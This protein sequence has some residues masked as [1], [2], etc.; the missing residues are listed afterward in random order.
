MCSNN[1]LS[2]LIPWLAIVRTNDPL[3]QGSRR[4][5]DQVRRHWPKFS[6]MHH[7]LL[8]RI[9]LHHELIPEVSLA[10]H[11]LEFMT[12]WS[13]DSSARH[14]MVP[15]RLGPRN[16]L[17]FYLWMI[18]HPPRHAHLAAAWSAYALLLFWMHT[19]IAYLSMFPEKVNSYKWLFHAKTIKSTRLPCLSTC[20]TY[21]LFD[22][23]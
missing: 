15:Q 10:R 2:L 7:S 8:A 3:A 5:I 23:F 17:T 4:A 12:S 21:Q 11:I 6:L 1:G 22:L 9:L 16:S 19:F 13:E 14:L 18:E 20:L